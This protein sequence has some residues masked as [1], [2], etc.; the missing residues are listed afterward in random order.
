MIGWWLWCS[1]L[2]EDPVAKPPAEDDLLDLPVQDSVRIERSQ[3]QW[4]INVGTRT[5]RVDSPATPDD[6]A[7][8][9]ALVASLL[10]DLDLEVALP[11]APEPAPVPAASLT[12]EPPRAQTWAGISTQIRPGLT[13]TLGL[14]LRSL[15]AG[16][17]GVGVEA[18]VWAPRSL[19]LLPSAFL[20]EGEVSTWLHIDAGPLT[21]SW[22]LGL[23]YRGYT[24]DRGF[25]AQHLKPVFHGM[26]GVPVLLGRRWMR[27]EVGLA[28]D[29]GRTRLH[30]NDSST[31][32]APVSVTVGATFGPRRR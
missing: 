30:V 11:P 16:A 28:A 1:A 9:R 22:G 29:V 24:H 13:P 32:L 4:T 26:V 20:L 19:S 12:V 31:L 5:L 18:T 25:V 8:L 23:A 21:V 27:P 3:H 15:R 10:Q 6:E 17:P 14:T 7:L 2:A